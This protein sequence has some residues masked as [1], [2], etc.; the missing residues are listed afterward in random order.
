MRATGQGGEID[1]KTKELITLA[2]VIHAR[3]GPC[4]KAHLAKAEKLGL[5]R[6]QIEEAMW[7]AVA[8]GGA[9]VKMFYDEVVAS[10]D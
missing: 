7:C 5:S 6:G 10:E 8:M 1:A 4:L 2:L 9:P 3:C